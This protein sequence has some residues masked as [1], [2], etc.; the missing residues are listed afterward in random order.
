MSQFSDTESF[1]RATLPGRAAACA[2]PHH[3]RSAAAWFQ[4]RFPGRVLYAVKANPA[5]WALEAVRAA[6]VTW[7]DVTGD[8]EFDGIAPLLG[9]QTAFMHPVKAPGA[10]A[11]AY[12]DRHCRVFAL[13]HERERLKIMAATGQARDLT[14]MIRVAV[15]NEDAILPLGV[16]FGVAGEE[17]LALLASSRL[18][19]ERL[20]VSFHV[21]S[22]CMDPASFMRGIETVDALVREAG[23]TLDIIDVGGGFPC[24]Y[25]G[26]RPPPMEDYLSAITAAVAASPVCAGAELW[27]EPGRAIA[28]ESESIL[29][30]VELRKG[31]ALYLNDGAFGHLY[32]AAHES[33]RFPAR[34]IRPE[35]ASTAS[36]E[37]FQLWG[38]TCDA[39]DHM[40]GP[41]LLPADT[42]EGDYVEFGLVG[43]YGRA[44]RSSFNGFGAFDEVFVSDTPFTGLVTRADASA[45]QATAMVG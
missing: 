45:P 31:D 34:L 21:G 37:P 22:Q 15:S 8:T 6:G 19:A 24:A 25:P 26:L 12:Q 23:V 35:G 32:D 33:W 41:F 20:G 42:R 4:S 11:R 39:A 28:A 44:M 27:C 30:R 7:F 43:A 1:V 9:A 3:I 16:K 17:A 14:L 13:D 10:I 2:R 38:P 29:T 5:P 36:L 18:C 40:P